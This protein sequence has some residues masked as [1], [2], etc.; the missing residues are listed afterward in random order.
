M[1]PETLASALRRI[2]DRLTV[3][4]RR[5]IA[6]PCIARESAGELEEIAHELEKETP[7]PTT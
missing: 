5:M 2:S 3:G 4:S 7:C 1:T 6:L